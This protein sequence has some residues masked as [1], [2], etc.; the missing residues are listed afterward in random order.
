[1]C[2]SII[3]V[4]GFGG[5]VFTSLRASRDPEL[6]SVKALLM[7]MIL[8]IPVMGVFPGASGFLIWSA[9]GLCSSWSSALSAD[10]QRAS[11][12]GEGWSPGLV[13]ES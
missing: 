4:I 1:M 2:G 8:Q 13:R 5:A 7:G 11:L 12:A 3:F 10:R 9:I 6:L